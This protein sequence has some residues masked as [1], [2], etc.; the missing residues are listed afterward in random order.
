MDDLSYSAPNIIYE[1]H[2]ERAHISRRECGAI[3]RLAD[4][5]E[6]DTEAGKQPTYRN[7][8]RRR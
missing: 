3:E 1:D 4:H 6:L 2:E 7:L 5:L 8:Y